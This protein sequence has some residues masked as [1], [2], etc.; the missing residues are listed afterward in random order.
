MAFRERYTGLIN[1]YRAHLPVSEDTRISSLGESNTPLI[2]PK[3]V[4][5]PQLSKVRI[6]RSVLGTKFNSSIRP[7]IHA[8]VPFIS[9]PLTSA[10]AVR[11]PMLTP[12]PKFT[13]RNSSN[14]CPCIE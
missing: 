14:G 7:M 5:N 2:R 4:P 11:R 1:S 12:Y 6:R 9:M 3:N 10:T 8:R 13:K